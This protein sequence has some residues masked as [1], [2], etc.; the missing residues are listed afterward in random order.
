MREEFTCENCRKTFPKGWTDDEADKE[1][2]EIWGVEAANSKVGAG[3]VVVCDDCF[4][5]IHPSKYPQL[6]DR[7]INEIHEKNL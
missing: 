7:A 3:M 2:K 6:W 1:A 4:Q 5:E